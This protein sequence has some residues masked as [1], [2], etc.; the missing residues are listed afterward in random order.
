MSRY[1]PSEPR[2]VRGG[3]DPFARS[4]LAY[5]PADKHAHR[6]CA[7]C[8]QGPDPRRP[9]KHYWHVQDGRDDGPDTR[10]AFCSRSCWESFQ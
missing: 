8:G 2:Y 3:R 4:S 1:A 5:V 6:S 10:R 9:L 7:W